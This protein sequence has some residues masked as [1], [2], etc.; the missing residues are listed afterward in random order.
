MGTSVTVSMHTRRA[1]DAAYGGGI[2]GLKRAGR[3]IKSIADQHVPT[4]GTTGLLE[5][6]GVVDE[7]DGIVRVSY[8]GN[9]AYWGIVL[10]A[11]PEFRF[12]GGR[13]ALFLEKGVAD[14]RKIATAI[15]ASLR[16]AFNKAGG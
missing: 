15:S 7:K 6:S 11:H 1:L 5:S 12:Q 14:T 2:D 3:E 16:D 4:G 13:Q 9:G 8:G 10:H